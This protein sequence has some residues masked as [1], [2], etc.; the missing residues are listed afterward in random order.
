MFRA[1][2]GRAFDSTAT[3]N[4]EDSKATSQGKE[5]GADAASAGGEDEYEY[6]F[7]EEDDNLLDLI[8]GFNQRDDKK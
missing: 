2:F 7:E 8:A 4:A 3:I 5:A 6:E 1:R